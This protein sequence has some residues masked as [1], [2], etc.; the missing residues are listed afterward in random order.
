[1]AKFKFVGFQEHVEIPE[2]YELLKVSEIIES[3]ES[4]ESLF[5]LIGT[6]AGLS[7]WFYKV[8]ELD[9]R[10][11]GKVSFDDKAE[12]KFEGRCTAI[13]M[14]R[15][16]SLLADPFGQLNIKISS[17]SSGSQLEITFAILTDRKE[18]MHALYIEFINA[19]KARLQP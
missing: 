8:N 6:P 1:M 14:G 9:S 15:E 13:T 12:N 10:P 7:Q 5:M 3:G 11:G 19:L 18:E 16:I 2:G 17:T 4:R